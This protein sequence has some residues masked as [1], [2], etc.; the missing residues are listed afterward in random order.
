D[1]QDF[2]SVKNCQRNSVVGFSSQVVH[3][4]LAIVLNCFLGDLADDFAQEFSPKGWPCG[5]SHTSDPSSAG[6]LTTIGIACRHARLGRIVAVVGMRV[7]W[8]RIFGCL[9]FGA[10]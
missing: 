4:S 1:A 7:W 8:M 10:H 9:Y 2:Y 3:F 6:P 5:D